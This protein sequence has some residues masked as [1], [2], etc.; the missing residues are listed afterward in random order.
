MPIVHRPTDRPH[1]RSESCGE[2]FDLSFGFRM[3]VCFLKCA[4]AQ[5]TNVSVVVLFFFALFDLIGNRFRREA[6]RK[7]LYHWQCLR[8]W[9]KENAGAKERKETRFPF[10]PGPWRPLTGGP[11]VNLLKL[12]Y[13]FCFRV[14]RVIAT[15]LFVFG[16]GSSLS[17]ARGTRSITCPQSGWRKL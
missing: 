3:Y 6:K 14:F 7:Q 17:S 1:H 16:I 8:L 11:T 15:V 2:T 12:R 9:R 4:E 10:S 13:L 5:D